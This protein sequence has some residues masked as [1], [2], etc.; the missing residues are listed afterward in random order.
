MLR[1]MPFSLQRSRTCQYLMPD[2]YRTFVAVFTV[3]L[4]PKALAWFAVLVLATLVY[5]WPGIGLKARPGLDM[6]AQLGYLLVFVL[7]S[8]LNGVPQLPWFTFAFGALFAMHSHLFGE[9]MDV[10]PGPAREPAHDRRCHRRA[11]CKSPDDHSS[12]VRKRTRLDLAA[13]PLHRRCPRARR[14]LV[15]H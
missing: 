14:G 13:R 6:A 9:I 1:G 2:P 12:F 3:L 10:E 4:G 15:P 8:W 7:S 5:N 11:P